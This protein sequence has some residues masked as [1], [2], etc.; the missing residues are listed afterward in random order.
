MSSSS[1]RDPVA[2]LNKVWDRRGESTVD[3]TAVDL[4]GGCSI[5]FSGHG[6]DSWKTTNGLSLILTNMFA[7][8]DKL[9]QRWETTSDVCVNLCLPDGFSCCETEKQMIHQ[10]KIARSV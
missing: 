6:D 8:Q 5:Q 10:M 7:V 4:G 1:D 2:I 3:E 9:I